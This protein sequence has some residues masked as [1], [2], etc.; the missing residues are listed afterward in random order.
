MLGTGSLLFCSWLDFS[1]PVVYDFSNY[2]LLWLMKV[3][4]TD[5][6]SMP[7][8][9]PLNLRK[10]AL[11]VNNLVTASSVHFMLLRLIYHEQVLHSFEVSDLVHVVLFLVG[12][13]RSKNVAA[14]K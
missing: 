8:R 9:D 13:L 11:F 10:L 7:E 12:Y 5:S 3:S 1:I 14:T 2:V 6:D 4:S